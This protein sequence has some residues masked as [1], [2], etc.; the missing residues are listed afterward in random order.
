M[1]TKVMCLVLVCMVVVVPSTEAITC[2]QVVSTLAPC[3]GYL[4]RGGVVPPACCGGV[5]G[6]NNVA[7]STP[8]RR[9]TCGCL[10]VLYSSV[11][12]VNLGFASSLPGKCGV[13]IPYKI[14]P[15]T[16]C[17]KVT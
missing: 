14:S 9:T 12:G 6:L 5:I 15:S 2:G 16:D 10:K 8:D 7:N 3:L 4:T 1:A 13:N 11:S 17:S